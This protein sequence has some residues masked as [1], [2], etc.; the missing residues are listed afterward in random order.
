[1]PGTKSWYNP[2]MD[3]VGKIPYLTSDN[4]GKKLRRAIPKSLQA[5]AG[6]A[7]WTERV[8]GITAAQIKK[9]AHLFAATTDAKL[10]ELRRA[11]KESPSPQQDANSIGATI[12]I[13]KTDA[14]HI[15]LRFFQDAEQ[16][17][18]ESGAYFADHE[19][20][21]FP[22][23]LSDA[24]EEYAAAWCE[25]AGVRRY[26]DWTALKALVTYGYAPASLLEP[27]PSRSGRKGLFK[28]PEALRENRDFQ[29]L[30]RMLERAQVELAGRRLAAL[31]NGSIPPIRDEFFRAG[32]ASAIFPGAP[33]RPMASRKTVAELIAL[34]E[35]RKRVEVGP[36][37]F[38]QLRIPC[39][40]M[41]EQWGD[42]FLL[43]EV[44][45]QHC[46]D[47]VGLFV[48]IP[49][50]AAQ[51]FKGMSLDAA[52]RAY[53]KRHGHSAVRYDEARK[54]LA[55]LKQIFSLA[56]HQDWIPDNPAAKVDV[57]KT[58][59]QSKKHEERERSYQPFD[60]D[61]LRRIF[62]APLYTGC[63][64]DE[65]RFNERGTRIVR[66]HRFWG[67]LIALWTGAR[68]GEIIQLERG[69][70]REMDGVWFIAITDQEE[71]AY[72]P[73]EFRKRL[74]N[75]NALRDIPIHPE[76]IRVGFLDWA[77]ERRPGRLFPEASD[78]SADKR[79]QSASK[80]Y[81]TFLRSRAVWVPRRKVFHSF[82]DTF[83]DAL[84]AAGVP[85]EMRNAINGWA[86]QQ[87]KMD[88]RY[89]RGHKVQQLSAEIEKVT[90][91]CLDF[92]HLWTSG[93]G[94]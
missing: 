90:Y 77:L 49:A 2:G 32:G 80:R 20:P 52:A 66:R 53:E 65:Y 76:L 86:N 92:S 55:V 47:L 42:G 3:D 39:R 87:S 71:I 48:R 82:R 45:R 22:D 88:Q 61:D 27:R 34:F 40:A 14:Q 62:S 16:Q 46:Q 8:N 9:R 36:S 64:D 93:A 67:P 19:C 89:G 23:I 54:H 13:S 91:P 78:G 30:C 7:T 94:R 12:A 17:N 60:D 35:Q 37:R 15:A 33:G 28:V 79:F 29:F 24:G 74:K 57:P 5:A 69:D 38:S 68:M 73:R 1:L 81:A 21:D 63:I 83:N 10:D 11:A 4:A 18:I 84:R 72:D 44:T 41:R 50:H 56:V 43:S 6:K 26:S 70:I 59:R 25:A 85:L 31:Q 51:H 58:A 75:R